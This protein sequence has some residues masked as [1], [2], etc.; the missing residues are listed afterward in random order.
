MSITWNDHEEL[1][2]LKKILIERFDL[3]AQLGVGGFG[4]VFKLEDKKLGRECA[5][6]VLDF[7]KLSKRE[8]SIADEIKKRFLREARA[9]AKC[10]H[11][12]IVSIYDI[13]DENNFPYLIMEYIEGKG[14]D[15]VI[16]EKGKLELNE[17]LNI[18]RGI[19]SA[20]GY[21]HSLDLIHRD[22]KP[23]NVMIETKSERTVII[24]FGLVKDLISSSLSQTQGQMGTPLYMAPEQW[25]DSK[26]VNFKVDIYSFGAI[27]Y[28]MATG[29]APFKGTHLEVMHKHLNDPVPD[30]KEKNTNIYKRIN[31]LIK[32]AMAKNEKDRG[33]LNYYTN[34]LK[35]LTELLKEKIDAKKIEK[36]KESTP[37]H[38]RNFY[39]ISVYAALIV[40]IIISYV[41]FKEYL[42]DPPE[43]VDVTTTQ[44]LTSLEQAKKPPLIEKTGDK[45]QPIPLPQEEKRADSLSKEKTG[46]ENK[47]QPEKK[48]P[49]S[50]PMEITP[51]KPINFE[52]RDITSKKPIEGVRIRLGRDVKDTD[53]N[54]KVT[55]EIEPDT[56]PK[57]LIV[58]DGYEILKGNVNDLT[59]A[60][61][62]IKP[63]VKTPISIESEKNIPRYTPSQK[64]ISFEI[65]DKA[66]KKPIKGVRIKLGR[67]VKDTDQSGK[68]NFDIDQNSN[69]KYLIV[70]DGYEIKEGNV[71]DLTKAP[72]YLEPIVKPPINIAKI[73]II[74]PA[75]Y[76]GALI[77]VGKENMYKYQLKPNVPTVDLEVVGNLKE[78]KV[79]LTPALVGNK[80]YQAFLNPE[81]GI[82][83]I[84]PIW[85]LRNITFQFIAEGDCIE[86]PINLDVILNE[87]Y[88]ENDE[89]GS[90]RYSFELSQPT[91]QKTLKIPFGKKQLKYIIKDQPS[92]EDKISII[93]INRDLWALT[94]QCRKP[95]LAV[96]L[97][98]TDSR[99]ALEKQRPLESEVFQLFKWYN[100]NKRYNDLYLGWVNYTGSDYKIIDF[101]DKEKNR[102]I[103]INNV[104]MEADRTEIVEKITEKV[105]EQFYNVNLS[106]TRQKL[107]KDE[108][109]IVMDRIF[110]PDEVLRL[111]EQPSNELNIKIIDIK[112]VLNND[113]LRKIYFNEE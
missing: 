77:I 39:R 29:E 108:L 61:M 57:Y 98:L 80:K 65:L 38:K 20:I 13:G 85:E 9:Y 12:N 74:N 36:K 8:E 25:K 42:T 16:A 58:K 15:K 4:K 104:I 53:Q 87:I 72:I 59:K 110:V 35:E 44:N 46:S 22:L 105:K 64:P 19:L 99:Y 93:P 96:V 37:G 102:Q 48:I 45:P 71:N 76:Q 52:I 112:E 113:K 27:L 100:Q 11:P 28:E 89:I 14:L 30:I 79:T 1:K 70:K 94:Y 3:M 101:N 84:K 2:I 51:Q 69:L 56:N 21:M 24:D 92:T 75:D 88:G 50:I 95:A 7:D 73:E 18:S 23:S 97:F 111:L 107:K 103:K 31:K 109:F 32:K 60:S 17:I 55:F 86:R 43:K 40:L 54:G 49:K 81:T 78:K 90:F 83:Q 106:S 47:E 63:I 91:N 82:I 66:S 5:L 68:V 33:N 34:E 6:K 10:K 41:F 62:Y 26:N 67:D